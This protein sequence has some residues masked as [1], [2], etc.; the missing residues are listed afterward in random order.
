MG[1][2]KSYLSLG[3]QTRKKNIRTY[4]PGVWSLIVYYNAEN[5][6]K[7]VSRCFLVTQLRGNLLGLQETV[8]ELF[9]HLMPEKAWDIIRLHC[10][11]LTSS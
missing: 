8:T 2:N 1:N 4:L 5:G 9:L 10:Q 3:G 11:L 7:R 6:L